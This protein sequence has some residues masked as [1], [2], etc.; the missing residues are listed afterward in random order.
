[1]KAYDELTHRGKMRRMGQLARAALD[2]YGW[3]DAPHRLFVDNGNII[4]RVRAPRLALTHDADELFFDNHCALRIHQPGY[5]TAEAIA[6]ELAWLA[7]LRRD[8][9]LAVPEPVPTLQ[10]GLLTQVAVPGVSGPRNC[11]LL[12]WI[13][14]RLLTKGIGPQHMRAQGRLMAQLHQHAARWVPPQSFTRLSYDWEGLFGEGTGTGIPSSTL[15]E[16]VPERFNGP[17]AL[18][19]YDLQ[20]V[21]DAWG[22]GPN[23]YGLIHADLGVDANVLFW[24]GDARAIDFDDCRFGYW[25]FDLAI[26][27]EH[28]Q[29]D[30]AFPRLR[31][32]L[33]DGYAEM[34][35]LSQEQVRQLPLFLAACNALFVVWPVA[36]MYLFGESRYWTARLNRA[37]SLLEKY[38]SA[39]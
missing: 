14:G 23:V 5:Q 18:A 4:Y 2:A 32:A 37:G 8:A 25:M 12:R 21:M 26:A 15:W 29:E 16:L 20:Q 17:F 13:K 38:V 10:G 19:A 33:L 24:R 7:A 31:D 3:A 35:A 11:S 9:A 27:L 1:M 39:R 22:T 34:R 36:M 30:A 6:S 28:C